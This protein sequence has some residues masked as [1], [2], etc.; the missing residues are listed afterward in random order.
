MESQY[1]FNLNFFYNGLV[2]SSRNMLNASSGVA[3]LSKSY[4]EGYKLIESIISNT[5]QWSISRDDVTPSQKKPAGVHKVTETTTLT[6][7]IVQINQ[8]MKNMMTSPVIPIAEL[9]KVVTDT[10]EVACP[11]WFFHTKLCCG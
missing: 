2:P 6:A 5:C 3:L 1:A 7:Q 9:D 8:T 4:E 10:L 11:T